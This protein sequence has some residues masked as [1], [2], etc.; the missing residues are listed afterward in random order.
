MANEESI[1]RNAQV[2]AG[3]QGFYEQ[4]ANTLESF[5][6]TLQTSRFHDLHSDCI[7]GEL[8]IGDFDEE[9]RRTYLKEGTGEALKA[10]AAVFGGT[11]H[12]YL[13]VHAPVPTCTLGG[14]ITRIQTH[15]G[16][17]YPAKETAS[18]SIELHNV[19]TVHTITRYILGD[20]ALN[21]MVHVESSAFR[22]PQEIKRGNE[23]HVAAREKR[24]ET[25]FEPEEWEAITNNLVGFFGR[26]ITDLRQGPHIYEKNDPPFSAALLPEAEWEPVPTY[27]EM[28]RMEADM[29]G[30]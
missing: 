24:Q 15:G 18:G 17:A 25:R 2:S 10:G 29:G 9:P 21:Q 27:A 12:L 22:S 11:N 1:K 6:L 16:L 23:L 5:D 13:T 8:L 19:V 4:L 26:V 7:D 20:T 3:M 14:I 30:Y 28:A